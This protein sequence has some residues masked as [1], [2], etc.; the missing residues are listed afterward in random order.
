MIAYKQ[1]FKNSAR[2]KY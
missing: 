1:A 2:P